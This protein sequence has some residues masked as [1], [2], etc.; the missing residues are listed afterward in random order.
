M[1]KRKQKGNKSGQRMYEKLFNEQLKKT[2]YFKDKVAEMVM[3][4]ASLHK[5]V[6]KLGDALNVF[7]TVKSPANEY[8][9]ALTEEE[10]AALNDDDASVYDMIADQV[11]ALARARSII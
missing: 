10:I 5:E 11:L 4:T 1:L 3:C 9:V 7:Q 2:N 8:T 6:E